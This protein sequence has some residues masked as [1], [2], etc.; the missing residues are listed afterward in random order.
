MSGPKKM[1]HVVE[2]HFIFFSGERDPV[3]SG[4]GPSSPVQCS[5]GWLSGSRPTRTRHRL[6]L[7]VYVVGVCVSTYTVP[8]VEGLRVFDKPFFYTYWP[9]TCFR[10]TPF[11][12]LSLRLPPRTTIL[13]K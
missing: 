2:T 11:T 7:L 6:D 12:I 9:V 13:S 5:R 4:S 10:R 8:E 3:G 1:G